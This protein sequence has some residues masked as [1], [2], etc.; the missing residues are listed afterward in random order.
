MVTRKKAVDN[1]KKKSGTKNDSKHIKNGGESSSSS[2]SLSSFPISLAA[3]LSPLFLFGIVV[4]AMGLE[5][6]RNEISRFLGGGGL[7]GLG[8]DS[9]L[10]PEIHVAQSV[11]DWQKWDPPNPQIQAFLDQAC[12][13]KRQPKEKQK[14]E[15][16][17]EGLYASLA[18]CHDALRPE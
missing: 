14:E 2:S 4:L 3:V 17:N 8:H 5:G 16:E 6:V 13:P 15:K 1:P 18:Y 11:V 10:Q 7:K 12:R 9:P